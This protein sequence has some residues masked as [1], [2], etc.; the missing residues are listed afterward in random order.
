[1]IGIPT[2]VVDATEHLLRLA[3]DWNPRATD[4]AKVNDRWFTFAAG[5]GLDAAVVERVD[6]HPKLKAR[7]GPLYYA[8]SA[9]ATFLRDY[10]GDPPELIAELGGEEF[11]GVT[12][13]VQNTQ[14]YTFFGRRPVTLASGATLESGD[15]SGA[16]LERANPLD[17]PA[18]AYRLLS[19]RAQVGDH[20]RVHAFDGA[21]GLRVR[22]ADDRPVPLQV[23]G[24]FIGTH[25]EAVFSV[26]PGGLKIVG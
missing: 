6:A 9:T 19:R 16:V 12:V 21:D 13:A 14:P 15:L 26:L 24:D 5:A 25:Q 11:R 20:R 1:M 4:I 17:V 2:D 23:D 3:D 8:Q 22:S 10:V 7:F 18:F